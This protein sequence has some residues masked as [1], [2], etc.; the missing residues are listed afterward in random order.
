ME[1]NGARGCELGGKGQQGRV[2][3]RIGLHVLGI[4]AQQEDTQLTGWFPQQ[5]Y[6]MGQTRIG[7]VGVP[8]E[9]RKGIISE[10]KTKAGHTSQECYEPQVEVFKSYGRGPTA[11]EGK[12]TGITKRRIGQIQ[13]ANHVELGQKHKQT[14]P[15]TTF[16]GS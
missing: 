1:L 7:N 6:Q 8:V 3:I 9:T 11:S 14:M 15:S 4:G 5:R 2:V 13:D 16:S 10:G 12:T